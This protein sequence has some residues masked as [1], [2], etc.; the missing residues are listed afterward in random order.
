VGAT[1]AGL[2]CAHHHLYSSLAR[3][4]PAPAQTPTNFISVLKNVWWRLDAA[5]DLEMIYWS[6]KLGA[7]EALMAGTTCVIDH[8]ESPNAIEGSLEAIHRACTEVGIRVNV[9]YGVTDRWQDDGSFVDSVEPTS[10]MTNAARLGLDENR[11]ALEAGL[12]AMVGVHAAF[13]VSDE[14]LH[15][16]ADLAADFGVGVHIHVAEGPDDRDAARR[17]RD[18]A[19]DKWLVIHGVHLTEALRGTLVHN[20]RSN[21]N[22]SVGYANPHRSAMP[23]ALGTDG[24]GADMLEEARLGFA[25]LR[26][27]DLTSAADVVE[28]WITTSRGLFPASLSDRVTWNYDHADSIWHLVYTTGVRAQTIEVDGR[29]VLDAGLPVLVDLAEVRHQAARQAQR[30]HERLAAA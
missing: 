12:T 19:T 15:A 21:M 25:R 28:G 20:P 7:V 30:L 26:E 18:L 13:T 5:L 8:H 27:A 1:T 22:N 23:V 16:A 29:R 2:V 10:S 17:L 11:R 9:S 4:M 24:I 3:G 6:A 14:T